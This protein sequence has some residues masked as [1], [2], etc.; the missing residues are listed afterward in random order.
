MSEKSAAMTERPW[1]AGPW[2]VVGKATGRIH[3]AG[4]NKDIGSVEI[5]RVG[6][7]TDRELL[8]WNR[9]RWDADCRLIAASPDLFEA[10]EALLTVVESE[11]QVERDERPDGSHIAA[12]VRGYW[13]Q[14]RAAL[15]RARGETE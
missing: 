6:D 10:L 12:S 15:A 8:P 4:T 11:F 1:T 14:A 13:L 7:Y 3:Y 9:E 2:K 5:A